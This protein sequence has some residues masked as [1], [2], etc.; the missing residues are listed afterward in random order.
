M[1]KQLQKIPIYND[2]VLPYHFVQALIASNK[3]RHPAKKNTRHR[4]YWY[5]W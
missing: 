2:L 3:Y 5:Q 4:G 1:K